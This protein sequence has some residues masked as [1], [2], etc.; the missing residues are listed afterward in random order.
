ML[1][2]HEIVCFCTEKTTAEVKEYIRQNQA[3]GASFDGD[4]LMEV[5]KS[6]TDG[7][8]IGRC[9]GCLDEVEDMMCDYRDGKWT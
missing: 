7:Q 3:S 5:H 1:P 2:E 9:C 6:F 4:K 8:M